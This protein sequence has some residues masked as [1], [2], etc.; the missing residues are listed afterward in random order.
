MHSEGCNEAYGGNVDNA[1][2]YFH[3]SAWPRRLI[4]R[5]SGAVSLDPA[6][7]LAVM[8]GKPE[9]GQCLTDLFMFRDFGAF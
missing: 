2:D 3:D 1:L 5:R 7:F 6:Y 9:T 8:W 4:A